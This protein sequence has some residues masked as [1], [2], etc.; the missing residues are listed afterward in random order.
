[1]IL[2]AREK[3]QFYKSFIKLWAHS[4]IEKS[5]GD[6]LMIKPVDSMK[7]LNAIGSDDNS[8]GKLQVLEE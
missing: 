1:M 4:V 2:K 5:K 8:G 6:F 3:L 7:S